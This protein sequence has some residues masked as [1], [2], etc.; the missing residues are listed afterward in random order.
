MLALVVSGIGALVLFYCRWY[1]GDDDPPTRTGAVLV[2]FAGAMLGLVTSDDLI[3]LYVFWE[4]TTV[5]SYLLVGHNPTFAANRRAALTALIVTTFGGL[6]M[7]VG[8]VLLAVRYDTFS[9]SRVLDGR[10]G[11]AGSTPRWW[12]RRSCC[13][14]SARCRSRPWCR[15]TS[16]FPGRWPRRPRSA[17]TCTPPP[18]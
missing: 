1:F 11:R 17:R 7:L 9:L 4:L 2:A 5:F 18:W 16:G 12:W 15:S 10:G 8:I 14:W 6:A 13:C 3:G